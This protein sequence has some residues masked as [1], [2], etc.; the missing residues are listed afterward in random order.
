MVWFEPQ[1]DRRFF[2]VFGRYCLS[3]SAIIPILKRDN[4]LLEGEL[5][6]LYLVLWLQVHRECA[7]FLE[8]IL[9][10]IRDCW[11]ML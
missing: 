11:M 4:R 7:F 10:V 9:G 1:F 5:G 2:F 8:L 6:K 3:L